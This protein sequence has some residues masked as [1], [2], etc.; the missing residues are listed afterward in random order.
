MTTK[1]AANVLFLL[2]CA[3]CGGSGADPV[4]ALRDIAEA[5][6]SRTVGTEWKVE[7]EPTREIRQTEGWFPAK[8]GEITVSMQRK[9]PDG[10]TSHGRFRFVYHHKGGTWVFATMLY[11]TERLVNTKGVVV[12]SPT[13]W[14]NYTDVD[15]G[16]IIAVR[17]AFVPDGK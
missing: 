11:K 4:A 13:T 9:D 14:E 5:G 17:K 6:V 7:G 2:L 1:T 8:V 16:H 15:D 3:G 12:T 10:W